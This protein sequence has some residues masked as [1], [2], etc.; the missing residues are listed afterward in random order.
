VCL[1]WD[2]FLSDFGIFLLTDLSI[3]GV[4]VPKGA[5]VPKRLEN[6][7]DKP[8]ETSPK[9]EQ[10]L[11]Y[12][13]TCWAQ[14]FHQLFGPFLTRSVDHFWCP[15]APKWAPIW[16]VNGDCLGQGRKSAKRTL[17]AAGALFSRVQGVRF[18]TYFATFSRTFSKVAFGRSLGKFFVNFRVQVEPQGDQFGPTLGAKLGPIFKFIF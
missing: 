9:L 12:F 16:Y 3:L 13:P 10:F 6:G 11:T 4:W 2:P 17:A 1:F 15:G 5:R 14:C 18:G 8:K 7:S